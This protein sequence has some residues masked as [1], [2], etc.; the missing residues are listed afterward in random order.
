MEP[1]Q[2]TANTAAA[3]DTQSKL[4]FLRERTQFRALLLANPNHF[5][6]L[7]VSPFPPVLEIQQDTFYEQL[8]PVGFQPQMNRLEAVVYVNQPNGYGGG[9]CSAGTPEYVRFY[10]SFNNGATWQDLGLTSFTAYNIPGG[11]VGA[12]RLEYAV[13]LP[14]NP[15]RQT[16]KKPNLPLVRAILSWNDVPPP[17]DPNFPPIWG[18][19]VTVRIQ[20]EPARELVLKD[21]IEELKL[22]P[23]L[24]EQLE[25]EQK[26]IVQEPKPLAAAE[27]HARYRDKGVEP[28]RFALS[29][30]QKLIAQPIA[31]AAVAEKSLKAGL[32]GLEID[33]TK[34]IDKLFPVDGNTQY[35]EL[36][37][38]GLD[39]NLDT[40]V[41]V[42]KAKLPNGYSGSLCEAGS[43]EYVTFWADFDDTGTFETCL[44]TT[45]VHV[46]D[47]PHIPDDDLMYAVFLPVDLS[48]HR[49]PCHKG[50]K[51]VRIRA[52][53]SWQVPP[54]CANPNYVPV[55]GNREETL[56]H[57]KPGPVVQFGDNVPIIEIVGGAKAPDIDA[58]SGLAT[59]TSP[60][61]GFTANESPFGGEVLVSGHIAYGPDLSS[62][63]A[64][65]RYQVWVQP[66][67][68]AVQRLT[69]SFAVSRSRLLDGIWSF[70]PDVTQGT[71]PT[72]Y[73]YHEDLVTS[74][75]NAQIFVIG[76][77]L[78]RWQ[79]AGL[80]G[81]WDIFVT[82]ENPTNPA[83]HWTSNVVRICLDNTAPGV[84]VGITS[85]GG[86][87]ADFVIGDKIEGDYTVSD[88]HFG[89]LTLLV[90]PTT[91]GVFTEPAGLGVPA[92]PLVRSYPSV[93]TTG[94]SGTWELDTAGMARCGYVI[95][96]SAL[97]R[98]IVNSGGIGWYNRDLVGLCLREPEA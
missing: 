35:E 83:L 34:Y 61:A 22:S 3:V 23:D 79:T 38:I 88:A 89:N 77:L 16:C 43:R 25:P 39:P 20:I 46:H 71:D 7:K 37:G 95:E 56:I 12:K 76:N 80:S 26:L 48:A 9:V 6:N 36:M 93:P 44:G 5:G 50:A 32:P 27:L 62:G 82:V 54:P 68:G 29:E 55:W 75:G 1:N 60:T 63:A 41:G 66:V 78:A 67:G 57:I 33:L 18:N 11:T 47:I 53:L 51:V 8:G 69:N 90:L 14:F 13:T 49:Q 91:G 52:I 65:L 70:L 28:H 84:S 45:S 86:N 64:R 73:E 31:A 58:V 94:K 98:T 59:G 24:I 19:V 72:T 17:N 40:L 42:I 97:D 15:R 10:V 2:D 96:L 81:L 92:M 74:P 87:C 30:M 21:W 85:G 4:P